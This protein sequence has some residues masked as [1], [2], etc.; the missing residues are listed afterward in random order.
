MTALKNPLL[1]IPILSREDATIGNEKVLLHD[2]YKFSFRPKI[3]KLVTHTTEELDYQVGQSMPSPA[4]LLQQ[5]Y[6]EMEVSKLQRSSVDDILY[7]LD[8]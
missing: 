4:I 3:I 7:L 5:R 1:R 8:F 6:F 2:S